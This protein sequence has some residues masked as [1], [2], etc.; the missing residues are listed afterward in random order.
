MV[1]VGNRYRGVPGTAVP[2]LV[3][4]SSSYR[5]MISQQAASS[6]RNFRC[7]EDLDYGH[8]KGVHRV[9]KNVL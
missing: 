1:P 7:E 5:G 2:L 6:H 4:T 8:D 3:R 9:L